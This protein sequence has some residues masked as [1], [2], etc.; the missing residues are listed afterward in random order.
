MTTDGSCQTGSWKESCVEENP[1]NLLPSGWVAV[2][3]YS[4]TTCDTPEAIYANCMYEK[5]FLNLLVVCITL[6]TAHSGTR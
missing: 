2:T 1:L 5:F 3:K 6:I 4:G